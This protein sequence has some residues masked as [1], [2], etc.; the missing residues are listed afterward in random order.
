L[1]QCRRVEA[2]AEFFKALNITKEVLINEL[3]IKGQNFE[4][5]SVDVKKLIEPSIFDDQSI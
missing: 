4:V 5:D 3:K 2:Q 1:D